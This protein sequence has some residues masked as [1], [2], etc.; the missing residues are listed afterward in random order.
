MVGSWYIDTVFC[1]KLISVQNLNAVLRGVPLIRVF[2]QKQVL[3]ILKRI[4]F[5]GFISSDV[6]FSR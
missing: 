4:M 2:R 3:Q 6:W 1:I 5:N